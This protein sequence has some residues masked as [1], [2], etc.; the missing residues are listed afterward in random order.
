MET[1]IDV[2]KALLKQKNKFISKSYEDTPVRMSTKDTNSNNIKTRRVT[3]CW[4]PTDGPHQVWVN[5]DIEQLDRI[6][7]VSQSFG[8]E[9]TVTQSWL[10]SEDDERRNKTF[11]SSK[12]QDGDEP[13]TPSIPST[14]D[15]ISSWEPK[16]LKF[17]NAVKGD[18]NI[19]EDELVLKRYNELVLWE[20]KT[21]VSGIFSEKFELESFPFDCQEFQIQIA[22]QD[23]DSRCKVYPSPIQRNFMSLNL[24][25]MVQMEYKIHEPVIESYL[26]PVKVVSRDLVLSNDHRRI[27]R[28]KLKGERY[29]MPYFWQYI[30]MMVLMTAFS[31][32]IFTL[33]IDET[34]DRLNAITTIFLALVVQFALDNHLPKLSYS[35]FIDRY[36]RACKLF[37]ASVMLQ[38]SIVSWMISHKDVKISHNVDSYILVFNAIILLLGNG[39]FA[40]YCHRI[41]IPK[42]R[43]KLI[44]LSKSEALEVKNKFN[45]ENP[46]R[47]SMQKSVTSGI[48]EI[49]GNKEY[50]VQE[51]TIESWMAIQMQDPNHMVYCGKQ[52]ME[53][54]IQDLYRVE[55]NRCQLLHQGNLSD[56]LRN[57]LTGTWST[58]VE[59]DRIKILSAWMIVRYWDC[60][61][62]QILFTKITGDPNLPAGKVSLISEGIPL[63]GNNDSQPGKVLIRKDKEDPNGF[64]W[65][66]VRV[67]RTSVNTITTTHVKADNEGMKEQNEHAIG[68][69]LSHY[70]IDN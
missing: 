38:V 36:I 20:K 18:L 32:F 54:L 27:I 2:E 30:M 37:T 12:T 57:Y 4:Y 39:M 3:E 41:V 63:P 17:P 67:H 44:N 19:E 34:G 43:S 25:T 28:V 60:R 29:W 22:W 47:D 26:K 50:K 7:T 42:E 58:K 66:E 11:A 5:I 51:C 15:V 35:T 69:V 13:E 8:S 45:K 14:C 68:L 53:R 70:N 55:D 6:D 23:L 52:A 24:T 40:I 48:L 62:P 1:K 9:F 64:E 49:S 10:W 31:L 61:T 33:N 59:E 65:I 16:K 56:H 21:H 46:I